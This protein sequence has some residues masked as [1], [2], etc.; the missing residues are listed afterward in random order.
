MRGWEQSLQGFC[1][2]FREQVGIVDLLVLEKMRRGEGGIRVPLDVGCRLRLGT[3][4]S[5]K[6]ISIEKQEREKGRPR[7]DF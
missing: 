3:P 6:D 5:C 1:P 2:P 7:C 4:F